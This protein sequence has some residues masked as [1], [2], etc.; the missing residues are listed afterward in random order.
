MK[1]I[2]CTAVSACLIATSVCA[3]AAGLDGTQA[4]RLANLGIM[5]GDPDGNMR[6]T[7]T[8]TRAEAAKMLCMAKATE[9]EI[10]SEEI[11]DTFPD[12]SE[13]HWAYHYISYAK[14]LGI[15]NGDENGNFNPE[16]D[17]SN[18]EIAKEIVVLLGYEP[19]AAANGSYPMGYM[20]AATRFGITDGLTLAL[21]DAA[22]RQDVGIMIDN[23]LETPLM[24]NTSTTDE[25]EFSVLDGKNGN[26]LK[27][28]LTGRG[29]E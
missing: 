11:T 21:D 23:A 16:S 22:V 9:D 17:I 4:A 19:F 14:K 24:V 26:E 10:K 29:A 7:D 6:L 28:L 18:A 2:L 25:E 27:T 1:K 8:V 13:E 15:I 5:N 3:F 20:L 12:V